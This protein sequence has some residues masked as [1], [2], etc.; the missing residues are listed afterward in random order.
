MVR[1]QPLRGVFF[2]IAVNIAVAGL[3][4]SSSQASDPSIQAPPNFRAV[5]SAN[6]E[7][8]D[9][10]TIESDR[11]NEIY[12]PTTVIFPTDRRVT[13]VE[14]SDIR[15]R[16]L[17]NLYG[18]AW[19]TCIRATVCFWAQALHPITPAARKACEA[20]K[21]FAI[22][23]VENRVID[24]RTALVTDQCD[25]GNYVSL[26]IKRPVPKY[27]RNTQSQSGRQ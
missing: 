27:L 22:F 9:H 7:F 16:T 4:T 23:V 15:R 3:T 10:S 21:T 26:R 14:L 17:T 25:N 5:I 19:Q 20:Q 1:T 6:L 2:S 24:A 18:W 13:N 12:P 8:S 11:E